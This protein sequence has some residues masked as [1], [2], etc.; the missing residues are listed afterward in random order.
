VSTHT[1]VNLPSVALAVTVRNE[2]RLMRAHLEYHHF[3]GV[4]RAY[5]YLDDD[6]ETAATI[7]DL[8][9][10]EMRECVAPERFAGRGGL[11]HF[12]EHWHSHLSARQALNVM[13][14][15][16]R[17]EAHGCDWLLAV[18]ADEIVCLDRRTAGAGSLP[19]RLAQLP[20]HVDVASFPNLEVI[21]MPRT[22]G[23]VFRDARLFRSAS[24]PRR[25]VTDPRSGAV[26]TRAACFGHTAGKCAVRS[27][28][29]AVPR[30]SHGFVSERGQPLQ[31]RNVG[32]LLHYY[33]Y[34]FDDW[35]RRSRNYEGH[36]HRHV[37]G[38]EVEPQKL[39]WIQLVNESALELALSRDELDRYFRE[40]IAF[41]PEEIAI[42]RR[43]SWRHPLRPPIVEI[44]A[45]ADAFSTQ[46]RL[47]DY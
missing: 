42:H 35:L 21:Q 34:D 32:E 14:A 38:A 28:R 30:G 22:S 18:D 9:Y 40:T 11:R 41:S 10:V 25:D 15:M 47:R 1:A 16:A 24:A 20:E 13:D 8:E 31:A 46:A 12:V 44:P 26:L 7:A 39:L 3:L 17:A 27:R 36:P 2:A 6:Q 19:I 4:S 23:L 43:R 37:S 5:V 29:G 45:V 33:A